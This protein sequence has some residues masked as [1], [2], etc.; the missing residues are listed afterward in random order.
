MQ[1]TLNHFLMDVSDR[2]DSEGTTK[3]DR[4]T[5]AVQTIPNA[6]AFL[7]VTLMMLLKWQTDTS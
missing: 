6:K 2:R 1:A 3:Q 5:A 7:P 4:R